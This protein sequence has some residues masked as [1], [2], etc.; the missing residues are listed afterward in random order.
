MIARRV[1]QALLVSRDGVPCSC[2][3]VLLFTLCGHS[4]A[5]VTVQAHLTDPTGA[6]VPISFVQ[7]DLMNCGFNIPAVVQAPVRPP[8]SFVQRTVRMRP[9]AGVVSGTIYGNDEIS[10][11]GVQSSLWHV[12]AYSDSNTPIV[13]KNGVLSSHLSTAKIPTTESGESMTLP[14]LCPTPL[15]N[16]EKDCTRLHAR[17]MLS[18]CK[19]N[20][21]VG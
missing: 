12:T 4:L 1:R 10:C 19:C 11:G 16:T 6:A 9:V 17:Q 14:K 20:H 5:T 18:T 21:S 3:L 7:F 8:V 15:Q 13:C 2:L